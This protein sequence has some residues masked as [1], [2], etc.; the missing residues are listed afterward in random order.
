MFLI[1]CIFIKSN[2][3]FC[4]NIYEK[5]ELLLLTNGEK[6]NGFISNYFTHETFLNN[7]EDISYLY[8]S[9]IFFIIG[10]NEIKSLYIANS[11]I[12]PPAG[13]ITVT[14]DRTNGYNIY[15]ISSDYIYI[16]KYLIFIH[17]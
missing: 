10:E 7:T 17:Y 11:A 5:K 9:S 2:F 3:I 15:R 4:L 6:I 14:L 13:G 12:N 8:E 16:P 1:L